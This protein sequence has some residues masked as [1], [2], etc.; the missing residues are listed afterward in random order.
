MIHVRLERTIRL[1]LEGLRRQLLEVILIRES[2]HGDG[3]PLNQVRGRVRVGGVLDR[4]LKVGKPVLDVERLAPGGQVDEL[5]TAVAFG[6][7]PAIA[8][9]IDEHLA[10]AEVPVG[11]MMRVEEGES[12]EKKTLARA[13]GARRQWTTCLEELLEVVEH[14]CEIAIPL[15]VTSG[16]DKREDGEVHIVLAEQL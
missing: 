8:R 1:R 2:P 15:S 5:A 11:N 14:F 7:A 6:D 16:P 13:R 12:L 4:Q 9:P 10:G 3:H